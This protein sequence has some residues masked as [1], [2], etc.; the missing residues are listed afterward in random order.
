MSATVESTARDYVSK[1]KQTDPATALEL[2]TSALAHCQAAGLNV[3]FRP[4]EP[5]LIRVAGVTMTPGSDGAMLT[6]S[7][8]VAQVEPAPAG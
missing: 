2:L 1:G 8:V 3:G 5:L 7:G 6:L 4:G